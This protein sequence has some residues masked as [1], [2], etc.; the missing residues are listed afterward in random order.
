MMPE[1]DEFELDAEEIAALDDIATKTPA[2]RLK[3]ERL[4]RKAKEFRAVSDEAGEKFVEALR[5][6]YP[7]L[8]MEEHAHWTLAL[9]ALL[10]HIKYVGLRSL[11]ARPELITDGIETYPHLALVQNQLCTALLDHINESVKEWID[12]NPLVLTMKDLDG[13]EVE[14]AIVLEQGETLSYS[15]SK[16]LSVTSSSSEDSEDWGSW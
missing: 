13:N 9:S 14:G 10:H 3:A 6:D 12:G 7:G 2:K 4:T 15:A 1:H 5:A 11:C 16:P 8:L